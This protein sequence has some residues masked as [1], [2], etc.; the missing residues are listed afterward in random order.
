M[1]Y[2]LKA[3]ALYFLVFFPVSIF[4]VVNSFQGNA[5][6]DKYAYTGAVFLILLYSVLPSL[7]LGV[8]Y[9]KKYLRI[10]KGLFIVLNIGVV[11]FLIAGGMASGGANT[12]SAVFSSII[13]LGVLDFVII[14]I[15]RFLLRS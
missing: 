2:F 15:H 5:T 12:S 11:L 8:L 3:Y 6:M 7:L 9:W 10:L 1:N 14:K 13:A 4:F